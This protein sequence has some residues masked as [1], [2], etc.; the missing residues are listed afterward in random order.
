MNPSLSLKFNFKIFTLILC[1]IACDYVF[2]NTNSNATNANKDNINSLDNTTI[3]NPIGGYSNGCIANAQKA[4]FEHP[5]YQVIRQQNKRF[6]ADN[7]MIN[8]LDDLATNAHNKGLPILLIGDLSL[9]QGG[10]FQRSNHAS[11]QMGLD[12]DVWFRMFNK[13]LSNKALKKP[14][15]I[16]VVKDNYLEV[17]SNYNEKIFNL[18]KLA[19]EDSRVDR[20]FVNPAIKEKLCIDAK[21]NRKWLHKVRPWWGH[22]AHMHV[23]LL[24]PENK[25]Y[26]VN[27][28]PIPSVG[29]GCGTEV[30]SWLDEIRYPKP[31]KATKKSKP[32]KPQ[33]PKLCL[34]LLNKNKK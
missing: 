22:N 12:V 31:K 18:I 11:H 4:N 13:K 14:Y 9:E 28:A 25:P 7:E 26:C 1:L 23:R 10:P 27:S 19:A 17:N 30:T 6:Y 3:S 5:Y 33:P 20:I 8:F 32:K 29:D 21:D 16:N 2:A 24:C 34:E 15:A